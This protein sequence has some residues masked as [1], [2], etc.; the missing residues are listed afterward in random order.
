MVM[1]KDCLESEKF[2]VELHLFIHYHSFYVMKS[3]NSTKNVL[4]YFFLIT[5]QSHGI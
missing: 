4:I 1:D 2:T 5:I 3:S